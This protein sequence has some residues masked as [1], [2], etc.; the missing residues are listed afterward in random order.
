MYSIYKI[1]SDPVVDFAAEELKR[2]LR[3]MMPR[4][5]EIAIS[6][7]PE[8][9]DGFRLGLMSQFGLDTSEA[10][11]VELDDILHIDTDAQG[12]IIAGDNP[13]SVLLAVYKYLTI[14]GCRWLMPGV[15]GER[16][17]VKSIEPVNYHKMADCRYRGQCNEGAES[18]QAML[19]TIDYAP[20]IGM[21][22]YMLEFDIPS[23]YYNWYYDH[24]HNESNR[25]PEPVS[26][27]TVLQWKR[28]CETEMAKRGLQFH[29][30]GHGWTA[31]SFGI[32]SAGGWANKQENGVPEEMRKYIALVDGKRDLYKGVA[33]NTNF[34]MSNPEA[35][36]I[37]V[38]NVCDYAENNH[39]VDYL[40]VWLA[41]WQKNMC[42]CEA[43][44]VKRPSDWYVVL[45]NDIDAELTRRG[46]N[47]RIGVCI[48]S[49]TA[50]EPTCEYIK[51]PQ[52]FVMILGAITRS[53]LYS[54]PK[55]PQAELTP[56]VLNTSGR[57]DSMEEHMVR[58][59]LW[60]NFLPS[61]AVAYEYHFWKHQFYAPGVLSFARRLYE[62]VLSYRDN[63]LEGI[64][65]D[66]SQRSFF[67]NG[68]S[69]YVYAQTLF[70]NA[71]DFDALVRDYF[72]NAYGAAAQ[73]VLDFLR[74]IDRLLPHSYLEARH[75]IHRDKTKY[76]RPEL[77][78]QLASV[79]QV[80]VEFEKALQPYK[81]MPCRNQ[82]V[83]VRLMLRYAQY[84]RNLANALAIKCTGQDAQ[85]K[86]YMA[87]ADREFGKYELE[88][89]RYYDHTIAVTAHLEIFNTKSGEYM[90]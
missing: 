1:T 24:K 8:A 52:R 7:A 56:F 68:L 54:M 2:Y 27:E 31:D 74:R 42:E 85:A 11:D 20:K 83:A 64:I 79:E 51:N 71:V 45:L 32:N 66:G 33:V 57:L 23:V 59:K 55:D 18:Q 76:Y 40:H 9:K 84:C 61:P 47:S 38:K 21:N 73:T 22:V 88:L 44:S 15:D 12:G 41:D 36:A 10:A 39:N 13:R 50:Y 26:Q 34:C 62:D 90:Q 30:M 78:A 48:Y 67:P 75:S 58:L 37:V 81:N 86:E 28:A 53:Y 17:P 35:R 82:T 5:G 16:I 77:Q 65:E 89:E 46:L 29:D 4:C 70:D 43:C 6:Y 72:E 80:T 25:E 3:M 19:E 14:N 49:E 63:G 60:K 69:F 87:A